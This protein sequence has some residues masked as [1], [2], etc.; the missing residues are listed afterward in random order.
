M[1][2]RLDLREID[3]DPFLVDDTTALDIPGFRRPF[4]D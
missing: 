1:D 4:N 2:P 3:L